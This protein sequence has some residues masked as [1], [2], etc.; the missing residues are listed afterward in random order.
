MKTCQR[1]RVLFP[2]YPGKHLSARQ[3]SR[4]FK[5]T[6]HEAGITKP[7]TLHTMR[8]SFATHLLKR[9]DINLKHIRQP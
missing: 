3:I 9:F 4:L 7:V 2:G 1:A 8:H 6:A 5:Q